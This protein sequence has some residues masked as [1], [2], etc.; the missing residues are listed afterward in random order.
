[1]ETRLDIQPHAQ[2]IVDNV[3]R[4]IVG[5]RRELELV[6][7]GLLCQGHILIEDV[8]G[9]GKTML[10]RSLAQSLGCTFSR[11]QFTPDLLPS[12]VTGTSIFNQQ[13]RQFEFRPGP[14]IG[15][16]VLAD[17][18]NRATPKTQSAL[19]EAM[20]ERQI[21][22]DGVV[23]A[24][25]QPFMVIGTQNPI[26]YEGTFPLPEAQLDRFLLRVSLG[27]VS[28]RDEIQMIE[29]QQFQHPIVALATVV[30]QAEVVAMQE[31]V[32]HVFVSDAIKQYIVDLTFATRDSD[33]V[34]LGSSPRGSLGLFRAG[35][36]LA[37]IRGRDFVLPDDVKA[38][39]EPVLVHRIIVNPSAR[40]K[41]VSPKQI[42]ADIVQRVPL[43]EAKG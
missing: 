21:T 34:Y 37:A 6:L 14:L 15:Q 32:K 36:A 16:I 29:H 8:P 28:K 12:D 3:E 10:A 42:I 18:I 31:A 17:E 1:M 26:E 13:T 20:E 9:V 33:S 2:Q 5:K 38:V 7:I 4:V 23:H 40:L 30:S 43:P 19:L 39:I 24:L 27:Y 41:L 25:P 35:Q 11:I 22:I